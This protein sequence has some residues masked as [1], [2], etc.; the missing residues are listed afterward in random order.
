MATND[1]AKQRVRKALEKAMTKQ[2]AVTTA[3]LAQSLELSRSVTSHYLS[4]L[5]M[6]GEVKKIVG[7]PVRWYLDQQPISVAKMSTF[8]NLVGATGSQKALIE[9]CLAAVNYPAGGLNMVIT[10]NSGVGKTFLAQMI[11]QYARESGAI[12]TEAPFKVLN[13]ADYANNPEL[14]SSILFGYVK[15]AFT[16]AQ[17]DKAGLLA[18]ADGGYLFLDEIHRLSGENQEK[19]FTFMDTGHFRPI[20]ENQ[21]DVAAKVRFIFATTEDPKTTLLDTFTRRVPV[22]IHI[23]TYAERPLDERLE[24]IITLFRQ[25]SKR[26]QRSL[27]VMPE[28]AA[29]LLNLN[30]EG[31]IGTLKNRIKVACARAYNRATTMGLQLTLADF[32]DVKLE[33]SSSEALAVLSK[34]PLKVDFRQPLLPNQQMQ[35]SFSTA[36]VEI[37][38]GNADFSLS[39]VRNLLQSYALI[40]PRATNSYLHAVHADL[41]KKI[42]EQQFG[43]KNGHLYELLLFDLYQQKIVLP[44]EKAVQLSHFVDGHCARAKHVAANFYKHLPILEPTSHKL[45]VLLLAIGLSDMVDESINMH[46]LMV[47]HGSATATSIQAVVN[48]LCG[49]YLVDALDMPIET[50]VNDIIEQSR[51]AIASFDTTNGFVLI[52]DMGSL[53]QLYRQIKSKLTGDLL[54]INNL[55][56]VTALDTALKIQQKMPFNQLAEHASADYQISTQYFEGFSQQPNIVIS[57]MSGLGIS[58]QLRDI[59][60]T[61]LSQQVSVITMD[62]STLQQSVAENDIA[63][64]DATLLVI[65]TTNLP[66]KFAIKHLNIYDLLDPQGQ[67]LLNTILTPYLD[68]KTFDQLYN[69]LV[70]FLSVEGVT[71]RLSFLNPNIIIQE[72]ETVILKFENYYQV[73]FA[74]KIKLN[75]YMHISLMVE[76]LMTGLESQRSH[77]MPVPTDPKQQTFYEVAHGIFKPIE[78][79]YHITID[80]YELSLLYELF[81]AA[82]TL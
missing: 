3:E 73:K 19:L 20:G 32:D 41:F 78:L 35:Q 65:T 61:Y 44:A 17:Q 66:D 82:L 64:F 67:V 75:L 26:L 36:L 53:G 37:M 18:E 80:G 71:E 59:L 33:Q 51:Q 52:I 27:E 50:S 63:A 15:G 55:T 4:Q 11:G 30:P 34:T 57:C 13:C 48:Q 74:G 31:N 58:E 47:A 16:G 8:Q 29:Y 46:C 79:K 24:L 5:F 49:T 2:A 38:A 21:H 9:K 12:D 69:Q 54:V 81:K 40:Q 42:V 6:A 68:A 22:S 72:V 43:L 62:F 7:R 28:V 76:R 23:E 39:Q 14:L 77:S 70:R 45:L 60:Q 25:E 10:G 1:T 56:T